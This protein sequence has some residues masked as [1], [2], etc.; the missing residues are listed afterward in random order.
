M[1]RIALLHRG[2]ALL[3]LLFFA[4]GCTTL[5]S[6]RRESLW[7][8]DGF[9]RPGSGV[10]GPEGAA[11][12]PQRS[13]VGSD[14]SDIPFSSNT[15]LVLDVGAPGGG[16]RIERQYRLVDVNG[17]RFRG[18]PTEPGLGPVVLQTP[19]IQAV[20][21]RKFSVKKT[22]WLGVGIT[23]AVLVSAVGWSIWAV[24]HASN[25]TTTTSHHH[26]WD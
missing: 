21:V 3:T 14:G 11:A 17:E 12:A 5:Q 9:G 26:D 24:T 7:G 19:H 22:V 23:A 10:A 2:A 25:A 20:H 13:L 16:E 1:T 6:V 4:N 8:L 18:I 15:R